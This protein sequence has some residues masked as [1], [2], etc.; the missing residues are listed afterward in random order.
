[1]LS[2]LS[3]SCSL[4]ETRR[5]EG[6]KEGREGGREGG[7]ACMPLTCCT[8]VEVMVVRGREGGRDGGREGYNVP[9]GH[10]SMSRR[11]AQASRVRL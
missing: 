9:A 5:E 11:R 3:C 2:T 8:G 10:P 1:M 7:K 4:T 6:R